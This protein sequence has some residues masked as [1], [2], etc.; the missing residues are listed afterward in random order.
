[1]KENSEL[2]PVKLRLKIDLVPYPAR[3]EGLGKYARQMSRPYN[4]LSAVYTDIYL[5][6]DYR[7]RNSTTEVQVHIA[8][9]LSQINWSW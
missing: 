3:A 2:K 5:T 4:I 8:P 7:R 6:E 9:Q 1:M